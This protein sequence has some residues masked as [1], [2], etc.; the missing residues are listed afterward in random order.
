LKNYK[1][2]IQQKFSNGEYKLVPIRLED[3]YEIMKWRNEQIYHLRQ[4]EPLTIEQ[5]DAYFE[6][7]V[8]KIFDQE[9]PNQ[10]LFSFLKHDE[11]IGYGGLV[12]I[13]WEN[14]NAEVSFISKNVSHLDLWL[15][16]LKV[17]KEV[18]FQELHFN[19]IYTYAYDIRLELYG[20]LESSNFIL[21]SIFSNHVVNGT[22]TYDVRIHSCFNP[23]LEFWRRQALLSDA[24]KLYQWA[25]DP[26]IRVQSLQSE[27]IAWTSHLDWLYQKLQHP[28]NRMFIYYHK[29]QPIGNLRLDEVGEKYKIS[30]LVDADFRG[31]GFGSRII[32]D[33]LI[34]TQRTLIAEVKPDNLA[35][36][37]VFEKN[38]FKS[39]SSND[40]LNTWIYAR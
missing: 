13:N 27:T 2:L 34:I 40:N 8:A 14:R 17:L 29:N 38:N 25:N 37:K 39:L 21:E 24:K 32:E 3:R 6:N 33:A 35:S 1:C 23:F 20:I 7:V 15:P 31:K 9:Q 12:H 19:K 30:Y 36:N 4:N 10:I 5:Q 11:L 22:E 16:Y 18:A 26:T 28:I